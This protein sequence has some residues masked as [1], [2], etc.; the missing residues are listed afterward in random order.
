MK[1]FFLSLFLCVFFVQAAVAYEQKSFYSFSESSVKR[2]EVFSDYMENLKNKLRK[3]WVAPDFL[4]EGHVRV[5]F[6]IDKKGN[7]ISGDILESSGNL[8]FDESAVYAIHRSEPF[9]DFPQ[10]ASKEFLIINYSFDTSLIKTDR[11]NELYENAKRYMYSDRKLALRYID[12]A[13]EEVGGD[14]NSYYLYK[15]RAKIKEGL[16]D[17]IAAKSDLEQYMKLK[18]R[19]DVKRIHALKYR[20]EQEDT[21][22]LYYYLA[23][24]YEQIGDYEKAISSINKAIE[25]T[26]LNQQY[27][28]YRQELINKNKY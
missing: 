6:K 10:N 17:H 27:K 23:Y 12:E 15:C 20:A 14:E 1:K 2:N 9:G 13:I 16:G 19:I 28:R 22:F 25:R 4:E 5:Q 26:D 8:I 21:A 7:V 3:N 24:S 18:N 11:V